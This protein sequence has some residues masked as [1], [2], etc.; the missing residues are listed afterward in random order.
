MLI[1]GRSSITGWLGALV[2]LAAAV[3]AGATPASASS[4]AA[5]TARPVA[6][7]APLSKLIGQPV[8]HVTPPPATPNQAAP[9]AQAPKLPAG[10]RPACPSPKPGQVACEGIIRASAPKGAKASSATAGTNMNGA[11]AAAAAT[12][13]GLTPANLQSAYNLATTSATGGT[14][15]GMPEVIAITTAYD[16]ATAAQ[17]LAAYRAQFGM[18]PCITPAN[19]GNYSLPL[20]SGCVSKVSQDNQASSLPSSNTS[21]TATDSVQMD[22]V[23][24]ICPNCQILLVEASSA[25]D[26][27]LDQTLVTAENDADFVTGGWYGDESPSE[28]AADQLYLNAPGKAIVF[29]A[30]DSGAGTVWPADSQYVTSAGGTTLTADTS[31]SRGWDETAWSSTGG[32]CSSIAPK[33]SWETDDTS[34]NGCLNRTDNDVA[35]VGD[36]NTPIAAY[37]TAAGGWATGGSTVISAAIITAT[38]A[39]NGLPQAGTYPA[40]YPYQS[41]SSGDFNDI[42]SGSN[43]TC[44]SN[45][46]YLCTAGTGYDG[47]TGEGTPHGTAGLAY[48][49]SGDTVAVPDPGTK[50]Y[51]ENAKVNIPL[52]AS[53]SDSG[54]AITWTASGLPASLSINSATGAITGTAPSAAG[55]SK[56]TVTAT[57]ATG[58]SGSVSFNINALASLSGG[59]KAVS[60]PFTSSVTNMC[61]DDP[62][63]TY[64]AGTA[65]HVHSCNAGANQNWEFRPSAGPGS[66]GTISP[67][68]ATGMCLTMSGIATGSTS[69]IQPCTTGN[70]HQGWQIGTNGTLRNPYSGYCLA[71]PGNSTVN[72]TLLDLETCST[73]TTGQQWTLPASQ[74]LSAGGK[75]LDD[76][77]ASAAN[78]AI[79][80]NYACNGTG[81]QNWILKPN[82]TIQV[83]GTCLDMKGQSKVDGGLAELYT[84]NGGTNQEWEP[85]PDGEIM[86]ANSGKCL[87]DTTGVAG[88]QLQQQ[89]CYAQP[90]EI[91]EAS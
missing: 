42:T 9:R 81:A 84:C 80:D 17:D 55:T 89:D 77:Q 66:A 15:G 21:W 51:A 46:K 86:N 56:V 14:S 27:D 26:A 59:W 61:L 2:L 22:A 58:A 36:P 83:Q 5:A 85:L 20:G 67:A 13:S 8:R 10:E 29:P 62:A 7:K 64:T 6:G 65:I 3:I 18:T 54:Q 47:P 73:S 60:G 19:I 79:I 82:G 11:S 70:G 88:T 43:G 40:S 91:W 75:C 12:V 74:I 28:T 87:E 53:G 49:A 4:T 31:A 44:E 23:T 48:H 50:N 63:S 33:P 1:F 52:R 69:A 25:S 34:P 35:A 68:A 41:G 16:D 57:D 78:N 24:A 39:L 45:R 37:D 90:G 71:D 38:Y 32:G 30:G 72:P 76:Y